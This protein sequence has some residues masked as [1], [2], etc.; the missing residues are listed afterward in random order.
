MTGASAHRRALSLEQSRQR[1]VLLHTKDTFK[2]FK[3][4]DG[5]ITKTLKQLM[6][7]AC[8]ISPI[9][10]DLIFHWPIQ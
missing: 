8:A 1:P 10:V 2:L 5:K 9:D 3:I 6:G 4:L 7:G